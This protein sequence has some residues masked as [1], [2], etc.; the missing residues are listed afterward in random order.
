[1]QLAI[2]ST[3]DLSDVGFW[4]AVLGYEPA[5]DDSAVDPLGHGS[6][7][8]MQDLDPH[9]L[10]QGSRTS[11][12]SHFRSFSPGPRVVGIVTPSSSASES[13]SS[14]SPSS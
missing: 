5:A 14:S 12:M 7:V 2:A 11:P 3:P 4:R 8:W 1:M 13:F 6:T 9:G 10:D